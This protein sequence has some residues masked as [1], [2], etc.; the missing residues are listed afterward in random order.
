MDK[1]D[2][3]VFGEQYKIFALIDRDPKNDAVRKK[4]IKK[5]AELKIPVHRLLRYSIENYLTIDAIK[6]TLQRLPIA[7]ETIN[8]D[9]KVQDQLGLDVKD[10]ALRILRN[11]K[12]EDVDRT[13]LGEAMR[14]VRALLEP[15]TIAVAPARLVVDVK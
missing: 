5:C 4:F 11:M 3:S 10:H 7:V 2:L 14:K 13:D 1:L 12:F 15:E 8:P 9:T 6:L